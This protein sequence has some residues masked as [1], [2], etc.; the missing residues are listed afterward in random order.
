MLSKKKIRTQDLRV[1]VEVQL[2]KL[3]ID[4]LYNQK[5]KNFLYYH[6]V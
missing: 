4:Q 5:F 2:G 1:D 3:V 6:G